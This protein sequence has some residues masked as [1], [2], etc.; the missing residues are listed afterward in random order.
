MASSIRSA[1]LP[2]GVT[3]EYVERG[4]P[5]GIPVLLL[6][7]LS[8][9]WHSFERVLPN[10]PASLHV[11]AISQRGHGDS[12]RPEAGYRYRDFSADVVAFLDALDLEAAV[13]V[14]HSS[15]GSTV[16]RRF[17][18]DHPERTPAVVLVGAFASMPQ[19]PVVQELWE[20]AVSEM[21]DPVDPGFVREFQ[22]STLARPVPKAFLETIVE[23]SRKV[24][25]RVWKGVVGGD[26]QED[27]SQEVDRIRA[28]TLLVWGGRDELVPRGDQEAMVE[29]I[30]DARLV[31]FEDAGHGVHWEE[32]ERFASVLAEFAVSAAR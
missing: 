24:P 25:A 5:S 22:E 19:S 17:A 15:P 31:V 26:L 7:G 20:S 16:A 10:L 32:P 3:L 11:F 30:P 14:G 13:L 2:T 8:D 29:A 4:D 1:R 18:I 23:E 9:S 27:L 12:S 6:H 28:P 21:E